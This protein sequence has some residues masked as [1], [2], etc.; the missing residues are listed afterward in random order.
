MKGILIKIILPV[1]SFF[2]T[3]CGRGDN[4]YSDD[5]YRFEHVE[6][7]ADD[8]ARLF[9]QPML[10][11]ELQYL[12]LDIRSRIG[13]LYDAGE[14]SLALFFSFSIVDKVSRRDK[15]FADSIFGLSSGKSVF[16]K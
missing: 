16:L 5:T 15:V 9:R 13:R 1:L 12:L 11:V 8:Y 10:E 4:D 14:E 2:V 7:L 3:S 6:V